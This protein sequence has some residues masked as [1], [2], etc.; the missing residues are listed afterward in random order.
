[1]PADRPRRLILCGAGHA[2]IHVAANAGRLVSRGIQVSLIAP[3]PLWYSGMASG[4]LGGRYAEAEDCLDPALLIRAHGGTFVPGRV[5]G[6]DT[7]RSVVHLANGVELPFDAVSFNVG[8]EVDAG[9]LGPLPAT[10]RP[11]KPIAGLW[12]VLE[13][14]RQMTAVPGPQ[15]RVVVVGGGP[16][17]VEVAANLAQ[18]MTHHGDRVAVTLLARGERVLADRSAAAARAA[19]SALTRRGVLVRTHAA[20][21]RIDAHKAH[22]ADGEEVAFDLLLLATGLRPAGLMRAL[23]LPVGTDGGMSVTAHL[24]SPADQRVFGA[25]DCVSM[26][27]HDLPRIG[28]FG[29]RQAPVL[30]DNLEAF[31]T[32]GSLRP[33]VPQQRYLSILNLGRGEGLA[34]WG[35]WHWRSRWCMAWKDWLDRRWMRRYRRCAPPV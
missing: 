15:V 17:G 19:A 27:G 1:L 20:V 16:T 33:Y 10:A 8:S 9:S 35:R 3:G 23:P 13:G 18:S 31:L 25:G 24:Q 12:A 4:V 14:L 28:V 30:L 2:H 22:F 6:L 5:V 32:G 21:V 26:I 29:V 11:V 34:M 7:A